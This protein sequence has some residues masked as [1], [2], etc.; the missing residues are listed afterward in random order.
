[1]LAVLGAG[2]M[3]VVFRAEDPHLAR[4]VALKAILPGMAASDSARQRFLREARAAASIKHDHIVTI[5]QVGEDRSVLF[6]AMEFLEGQSLEGRLQRDGKLPLAEVLRIGREMAQALAA[7][8]QREL[9]HRDIKP[10]NIWLEGE[11]SRVKILDFGLA[12]TAREEGQLTQ[13]GAIVG[14]PAYMAPE[15][16]QSKSVD[17]RCD[18]FSLGCVLYRMATGEPPFKGT[19]LISTLMAVA[20]EEP[21]PPHELNRSLPRALSDLILSLLA[22]EP[23]GRPPS[24][25][26]VIESLERIGKQALRP[27]VRVAP[28]RESMDRTAAPTGPRSVPRRKEAEVVTAR[29][30]R[31]PKK[32]NPWLLGVGG[33]G[34]SPAAGSAGPVGQ[35]CLPGED[36]GRHP[37]RRGERAECGGLRRWGEG[38]RH[39]GR[40]RQ[41]GRDPRQA[42]YKEGPH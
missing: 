28:R 37:R 7:A 4:P 26:A 36:E 3:G 15:Q 38:H 40:R 25:Q 18:L 29:L 30:V 34:G 9:I 33:S 10:A 13:Q 17:S 27:G 20:T 22:K 14:T 6:L 35:R 41:E 5:Y 32:F 19:D 16:A 39:L 8:H 2:G 24:A 1:V 12:R 23:E 21:R 11:S 42:R 31:R